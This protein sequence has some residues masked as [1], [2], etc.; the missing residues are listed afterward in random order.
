MYRH[1]DTEPEGVG[2][3]TLIVYWYELHIFVLVVGAYS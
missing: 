3:I 1:I 2:V